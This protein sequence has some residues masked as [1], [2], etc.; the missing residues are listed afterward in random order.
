MCNFQLHDVEFGNM[1]TIL[2][3]ALPAL[4]QLKQESKIGYIGITGY[5]LGVLK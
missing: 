4:E 3:E 2:T 1:E 5:P